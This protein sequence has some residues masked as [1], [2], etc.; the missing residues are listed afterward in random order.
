MLICWGFPNGSEVK[1]LLA[2]LETQET[3]IQSVGQDDSLKEGMQSIPG[4]LPGAGKL[5]SV[6]LQRD[7]TAVSERI[8]LQQ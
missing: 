5:H 2:V 3:W 1:N 8:P 4:F 7:M 6:G